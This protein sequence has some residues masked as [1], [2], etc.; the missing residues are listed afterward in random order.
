MFPSLRQTT[1]RT[2]FTTLTAAYALILAAGTAHAQESRQTDVSDGY[3]N[4]SGSMHG[5]VVALS[6]ER[7]NHWGLVAQVDRTTG[8]DCGDCE[9]EFHDLAVLGGV[10]YS[11]HSTPRIIP[12]W[13]VLAGGL[14]SV[15][16]PY[17][18]ECGCLFGGRPSRIEEPG[19]TVDYFALQ[20]GGGVTMRLTPRF[21]VR[22]TADLQW[23]IPDQSKW[24]GTTFFPRVAIAGVVRLGK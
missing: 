16:Q 14:H 6:T 19:Y 7:T 18:Y 2:M 9:P 5:W 12:F 10:R 3:L 24:E 1:I 13:H 8:A 17:S 20:P 22:A 15:A 11:W 21:G 23:A 4:V